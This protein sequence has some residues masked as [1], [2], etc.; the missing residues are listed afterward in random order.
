MASASC[1]IAP[2]A[3]F[4]YLQEYLQSGGGPYAIPLQGI[5]AD[6]PLRHE[7]HRTTFVNYLRVSL[8]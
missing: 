8:R 5:A 1:P 7:W 3:Y 2:D 6:V 4:K